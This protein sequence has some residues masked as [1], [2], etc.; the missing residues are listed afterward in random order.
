M[1]DII[2]KIF[3]TVFWS[4]WKSC[5]LYL[6]STH[7]VCSKFK[8]AKILNPV[9]WFWFATTYP[10]PMC[11]TYLFWKFQA[12]RERNCDITSFVGHLVCS[13]YRVPWFSFFFILICRYLPKLQLWKLL[14]LET[15]GVPRKRYRYYFFHEAPS[16]YSIFRM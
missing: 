15:L 3:D 13:K 6:R 11:K 7:S 14:I 8:E 2:S 4:F 10:N 16:V 1:F 9:F 12:L 5:I